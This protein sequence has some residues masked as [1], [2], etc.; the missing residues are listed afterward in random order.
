MNAFIAVATLFLSLATAPP[1]PAVLPTGSYIIRLKSENSF[2]PFSSLVERF[3]SFQPE[4]NNIKHTYS[5]F[6]GV[7]GTFSSEFL[8]DLKKNHGDEIAYIERSG[9]VHAVADEPSTLGSQPNPPSWGLGRISQRTLKSGAPY[10]YPDSAGEGVEIFVIDTGILTTHN[11]LKGRAR[12]AYSTISEQEGDGNG[13]G[14]HCAGTI[15]GTTYGV[16]KKARVNA[17]RVLSSSG[18]GEDSDVV[19]AIDWVAASPT[20]KP[21]KCVISMSIGSDQTLQSIT[22]A[23]AAAHA[24]G[25]ISVAAAG[26]ESGDACKGSPASAPLAITVASSTSADRLSFF[27]NTGKCVDIIAPGSSITSSWIGS[28]SA[29]NTISGTSMATP[30]VAG[31]V[32]LLLAQKDYTSSDDVVKDLLGAATKD[33]IKGLDANT[34]NLLLFNSLSTQEL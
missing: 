22:D 8:A 28:D 13:H 1:A 5:I 4:S 34:P 25:I 9:R 15:A 7:S 10:T 6:P 24:K 27:S 16:A 18:N 21:F 2:T 3:N 17:V 12:F 14:T 23:V 33:A 30:H 11:D 31:V 32:A 20:C 19:K 29:K 26:N